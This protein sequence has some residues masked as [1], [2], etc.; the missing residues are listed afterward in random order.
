VVRIHAGE[1][2]PLTENLI[3]ASVDRWKLSEMPPVSE[4]FCYSYVC[5]RFLQAHREADV[6]LIRG[7]CSAS[8]PPSFSVFSS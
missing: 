3:K 6:Q 2:P 4:T 7:E 8:F 5:G 1:P